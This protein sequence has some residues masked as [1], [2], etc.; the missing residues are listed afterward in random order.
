MTPLGAR[1][2]GPHPMRG[3]LSVVILLL[4]VIVLWILNRKLLGHLG[5]HRAVPEFVLVHESKSTFSGQRSLEAYEDF[6]VILVERSAFAWHKN[7]VDM[8]SILSRPLLNPF[9]DL[10]VCC[11]LRYVK[12]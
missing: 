5:R 12:K 9:N 6:A 1:A 10:L 4:Q 7:A 8:L 2:T 11:S 3:G